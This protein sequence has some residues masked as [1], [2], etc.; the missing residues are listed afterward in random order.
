MQRW[1]GSSSSWDIE[2]GY[3]I[4]TARLP[5]SRAIAHPTPRRRIDG[6]D[7]GHILPVYQQRLNPDKKETGMSRLHKKWVHAIP[8]IVI[9]C[10]LILWWFSYPVTLVRKDGRIVSIEHIMIPGEFKNNDRGDHIV[11]EWANSPTA[12]KSWNFSSNNEKEASIANVAMKD[13]K[14]VSGDR[15]EILH[16]LD[17]SRI[18]L[19]ILALAAP[20][21]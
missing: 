12:S 6:E 9:L 4:D 10:F 18:N 21:P 19:T 3:A 14:I 17:E 20:L 2:E 13:D 1:P 15:V 16:G 7:D 5:W 11:M 8:V